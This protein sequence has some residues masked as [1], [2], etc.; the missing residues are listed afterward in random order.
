MEWFKTSVTPEL[1]LQI[2]LTAWSMQPREAL[3]YRTCV[4]YQ[5]MLKSAVWEIMRLESLL[6]DQQA[7]ALE[8]PS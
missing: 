5:D 2:E 7:Q 4:A 3:L 1:D 8:P 6:E